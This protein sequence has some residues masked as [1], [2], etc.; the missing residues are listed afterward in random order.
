MSARGAAPSAA[1]NHAGAVPGGAVIIDDSKLAR[2]IEAW[3]TLPARI[4]TGIA[5]MIRTFK[6]AGA[7]GPATDDHTPGPEPRPGEVRYRRR[8]GA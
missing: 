4:R 1:Q 5:T 8:L 7:A 6:P 2:L 3:L